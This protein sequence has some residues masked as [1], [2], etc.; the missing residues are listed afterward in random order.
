VFQFAFNFARFQLF[1]LDFFHACCLPQGKWF[2]GK[3]QQNDSG[4]SQHKSKEKV[5][6]DPVKGYRYEKSSL[7]G[8]VI[9]PCTGKEIWYLHG[10]N[11]DFSWLCVI[12]FK[13]EALQACLKPQFVQALRRL[14]RV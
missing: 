9:A 4:F 6:F 1:G 12:L 10:Q 2:L 11:W 13:S 3:F 8:S 14:S 7:Q 5:Y